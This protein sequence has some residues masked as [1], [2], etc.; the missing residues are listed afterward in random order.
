MVE[1][2]DANRYPFDKKAPGFSEPDASCVALEQA[3][4]KVFLQRLD[5]CANAGLADAECLGVTS[6]SGRFHLR[7][8]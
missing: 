4:T 2:I 5:P 6:S 1:V 7:Q 3:D 8:K